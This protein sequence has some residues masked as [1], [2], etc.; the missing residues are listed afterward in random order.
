M[1]KKLFAITAIGLS[2]MFASACGTNNNETEQPPADIVYEAAEEAPP[3]EVPREA[4]EIEGDFAVAT[5]DGR[6]INA[7]EI[8]FQIRQAEEMLFWE[9]VSTFG[10]FEI[11][12]DRDFRDG[13]TFGQYMRRRAVES[14]ALYQ[15][16]NDYA[17]DLGLY[18]NEDV[19][20]AIE[21]EI[22]IF[23][24]EHEPGEFQAF[25]TS[26]GIVDRSHLSRIF[27]QQDIA[28]LAINTIMANE[29]YFAQFEAYMAPD[30]SEDAEER[31]EALLVRAQAGEDFD[32]LVATYGE[33]PGMIGNL[34]GY[35]FLPGQMVPEFENATRELEIG[36]ISG[37]VE[38]D[39]GIHIIKRVEPIAENLMGGIPE[40]LDEDSMMG[41]KHILVSTTSAPLHERMLE[42][43]NRGF[44]GM[45][46]NSDLVFL[47]ELDNVPVEAQ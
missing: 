27:A 39:F 24:A 22:D 16:M 41:A 2:L 40:D 47:P 12:Y 10:E 34:Y 44:A 13:Y 30:T 42:A 35:T 31:A 8:G 15:I 18:L 37:L 1:K 43:I 7:S 21:S 6:L 20:Q 9:Y 29:D 46:E 32:Y 17:A 11:D 26:L 23:E 33:D 45:L 28:Q 5:I 38:S 25:L 36:G 19:L 4:V 3:Q 14:A